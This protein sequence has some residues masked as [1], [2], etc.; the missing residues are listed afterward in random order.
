MLPWVTNVWFTF[1]CATQREETN[2]LGDACV[3]CPPGAYNLDGSA[4]NEQKRQSGIGPPPDGFCQPCPRAGASCPGGSTVYAMEGWYTFEIE[5]RSARRTNSTKTTIE[6]YECPLEACAGNNTCKGG[7]TGLLC[8]YCPAGTAL[9]LNVCVECE[10][11]GAALS[12]LQIVVGI[13]AC[14]LLSLVLFLA[15]WRHVFPEN[16]VHASFDKARSIVYSLLERVAACIRKKG[17]KVNVDQASTRRAIQAAKIFFAFYQV[18]TGF[19][20]FKVPLPDILRSTIRY[21]HAIGKFSAST[22]SSTPAWAVLL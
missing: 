17:H 13:L 10:R 2:P 16:R 20:I 15:G 14:G 11:D 9:E 18:V 3:R 5:M 21:L 8:G 1:V 4:W 12:I 22:S 6:T 7:R 19:I